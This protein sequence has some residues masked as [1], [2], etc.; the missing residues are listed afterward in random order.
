MLLSIRFAISSALVVAITPFH[1]AAQEQSRTRPTREPVSPEE[2]A[3]RDAYWALTTL[4]DGENLKHI[5]PP[6]PAFRELALKAAQRALRAEQTPA[7]NFIRYRSGPVRMG[8]FQPPAG[9]PRQE[10]N[11][12]G[13]STTVALGGGGGSGSFDH[14]LLALGRYRNRRIINEAKLPRILGYP[15]DTGFHQA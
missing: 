7:V 2:R 9:A 14:F 11:I 1:V 3:A 5:K 15:G 13:P 12:Y 6:F 10:I 8:T 4:K